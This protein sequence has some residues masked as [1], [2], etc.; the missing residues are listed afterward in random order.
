MA[1]EDPQLARLYDYTKFHIGVYLL[2]AG[3]VVTLSGSETLSP[4]V[5]RV[6]NHPCLLM[7]TILAMA[8]AGLAG[9]IIASTCATAEKLSDVWKT[10]IGPWHFRWMSGAAWARLE[11][12]AFWFSAAFFSAAVFWPA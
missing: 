5:Q 4:A 9:G 2:A 12:T 10:P 1:E 3:A 8:V 6:V 11:H 7:L